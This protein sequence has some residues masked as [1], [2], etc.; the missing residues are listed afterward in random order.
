[1]LD[2]L[3]LGAGVTGCAIARWLTRYQVS[4]AIADSTADVAMG[5]SRANSAI[6]HAGYDCKPGS[7]MAKMNVEGNRLFTSW[8][9]DL[10]V[11][12]GRCGSLVLAF[13][14]DEMKTVKK[15]YDD[16]IAN[17][18]PGMRVLSAQETHAMQPGLSGEIVGSLYAATGGITCPYELTQAC[19]RAA[20]LNG[21]TFLF[22]WKATAIERQDGFLTVRNARGEWIDAKF[23][24]NAAGV[25]ADEIAAM[26]GD[27]SFTIRPRKGEY[28]LLDRASGANV[29]R[30]LF[31]TPGPMGKGVLVSPTV[32]GNTFAG[33]TAADQTDKEDTCVTEEGLGELRRLSRRTMPD[34]P[35]NKVITSFAGL[36][37]VAST[38]DFILGP[39]EAEPRLL[40]A[41]G[42]CSPGLTSAPAI[43]QFIAQSLEK[44]GLPLRE[45]ASWIRKLPIHKA[46]RTMDS[47][48]RA[49]AI[50]ENSLHK[51]IIC[52]CETVTEA[53]IVEAIRL[54]PGATTL[55]G[56]KRRTRAGMGRCQGG[57]CSPKVMAILARELHKP[58]EEITKF[59]GDSRLLVGTLREEART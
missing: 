9:E 40:H 58:M 47:E 10:S 59:G 39:S 22:D 30:V 15:L 29:Q 19:A 44:A 6:V 31:Q 2:V 5:A 57:F 55:D 16:G 49:A 20:A 27:T 34:F 53:E 24:I 46:F 33:P 17:G 3:I 12:L 43:A 1:M 35:L 52:R 14:Q 56:V 38:G 8:C 51:H 18:V 28:M 42:I 25:Y 48:E 32:D 21:A 23:V 26:A 50:E 41:A 11:P 13:S 37:A 45:K 7:F 4:V 54:S 36:R